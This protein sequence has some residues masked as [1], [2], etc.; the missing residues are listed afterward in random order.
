MECARIVAEKDGTTVRF[1]TAAWTSAVASRH[2]DDGTTSFI[3]IDPAILGLEFVV[4][5]SADK[6]TLTT[7]DGQHTYVFSEATGTT[8]SSP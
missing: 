6:R 7:R 5:R 1:R 3:T 2:N 8:G 4:G